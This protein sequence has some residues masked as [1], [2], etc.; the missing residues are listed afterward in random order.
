MRKKREKLGNQ[1]KSLSYKQLP[2]V[3]VDK[4]TLCFTASSISSVFH[5]RHQPNKFNSK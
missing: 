4:W 2:V 1:N 3:L 5:D